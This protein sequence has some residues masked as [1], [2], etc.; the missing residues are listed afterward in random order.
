MNKDNILDGMTETISLNKIVEFDGV[1]VLSMTADVRSEPD[2]QM[3][4]TVSVL[5][6]TLYTENLEYF[7]KEVQEFKQ[8]VH[9]REN[10]LFSFYYPE[11]EEEVEEVDEDIEEGNEIPTDEELVNPDEEPAVDTD[12]EEISEPVE[13]PE[14]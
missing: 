12:E 11:K 6:N 5:N 7:R 14:P 8:V 10:Y 4:Y 9:E 3:N 1:Q 13:E 2:S